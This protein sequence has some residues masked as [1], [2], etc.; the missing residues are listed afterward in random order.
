MNKRFFLIRLRTVLLFLSILCLLMTLIFLFKYLAE[1]NTKETVIAAPTEISHKVLFINSYTP[2]YFTYEKQ[3]KG[4]NKVLYPHGI[5]YDIVFM[6]SNMRGSNLHKY[7]AILLGDDAALTF[8]LKYQDELF[9]RIPMVYFGINDYKL[10]L[11][12][13]KNPYM[14]GCYENDYLE[15]TMNLA[16]KLFPQRKTLVALHDKTTTGMSDIS[17]FWSF[18]DKFSDYAFVDLDTTLL[19]QTDLISLLESLPKDS[20]L[21]YMNCYS[22][23]AGDN[24]SILS[25]TSTIVRYANVPI[26]RN[27]VGGENMGVLG[28][29]HMDIEEHSRLAAEMVVSIL[30]GKDLAKIPFLE[31]TQSETTFD[32]HLMKKYNLD[33][34][35]LPEDTIFINK[36]VSFFGYYSSILPTAFMLFITLILLLFFSRVGK[37]IANTYIDELKTSTKKLTESQELLRYQAEYDEVLDVLNRRTITEWLRNTLTSSS[38]YSIII[39]DIDDFK[40]LNENYGHSLADSILQYIV[41]LLKGMVEAG[42]WKIARFGGDELMLVIPE[43]VLTMDSPIVRQLFAAIRAPIPLGDETLAITASMGASCSD[44]ITPPEQ[45]IINAETA[46]YEAKTHGK[47]GIIIYD[48]KMKEKALEEIRIKEK[49]QRAFDN[50]GFFMLYQPQIDAKTKEVSGFEAL[51]RMKEPGIY[52]GQFIPVAERSGWIWKIGR[53]TTEL[54]IKQLALWRDAGKELHPVSV[55]FSSNQLNDHGYVDFVE[56]LLKKYNIPATLLEIEITE[57]LFLEKSALADE[58]F[59][60]FKDLGIRLLMDDFGT[61]Y[62]SLGYLTYIPVDIVKLDKSLVDAYLVDGKDSFIKNIIHL[63]HDLDKNM[64]IEG[65]EEEWQYQRLCE[66][67]ADTIQGYFFSKPIPADDAISFQVK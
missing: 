9:Q 57:G 2:L 45:H 39:I 15:E 13:S 28:G 67:G 34:N 64:I 62:S 54:V 40:M 38:V 66:F 52:P 5:E 48:D 44:G 56:D 41:A 65:V 20:I 61:G 47:N 6:D 35:L 10:A 16:I 12:A 49:L 19:T 37:L 21:F 59:K 18:R 53:I 36:P 46:M 29:V 14:V 23:K 42:G 3:T 7:E 4:L 50:D 11:E 31:K 55:N 1:R 25:R 30:N 58:I 60:R 32:Y 27:F 43:E 51:V 17:V 63:M 33:F 24:H 22:D 26:F 8:A